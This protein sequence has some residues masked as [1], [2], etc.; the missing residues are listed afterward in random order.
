L[1]PYIRFHVFNGGFKDSDDPDTGFIKSLL[2]EGD[3][4]YTQIAQGTCAI[5]VEG[6][7]DLFSF[8]IGEL[9]RFAFDCCGSKINGS[10]LFLRQGL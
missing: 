8:E 6:K 5:T 9:K 2:P 1:P 4:V 3:L 10:L 7:E